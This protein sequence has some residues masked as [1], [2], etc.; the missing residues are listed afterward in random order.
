MHCMHVCVQ[1]C[2]HACFVWRCLCFLHTF[3]L[4]HSCFI[5]M[6]TD[7][8]FLFNYYYYSPAQRGLVARQDLKRVQKPFVSNHY[9][10]TSAVS[11]SAAAPFIESS[12][13]VV[14]DVTFGQLRSSS[15]DDC[16]RVKTVSVLRH[17][18]RHHLCLFPVPQHVSCILLYLVTLTY[19]R[20]SS[21]G[22]VSVCLQP[23]CGC[24][25]RCRQPSC[26]KH[27]WQAVWTWMADGFKDDA[28][29][30]AGD[31]GWWV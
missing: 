7:D 13:S 28:L 4:V 24:V 12:A 18:C 30:M 20:C 17:H 2:E 23:A 19:G 16:C 21:C 29:L 14:N 5:Y 31:V 10:S 8:N 3:S 15:G 11:V 22:L 26:F 6:S 1:R 9:N 27:T 25:S